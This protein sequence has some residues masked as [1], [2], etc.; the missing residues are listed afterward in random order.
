[1]ATASVVT[2]G[3]LFQLGAGTV[4]TVLPSA[5]TYT[6]VGEVR[7]FSG[8]GGG[9]ANEIDVTHFLSTAKEKRLGF[10]DQGTMSL[11]LNFVPTD[12]MQKQLEIVR[13]TGTPRNF[14]ITL[15]DGTKVELVGSV[16]TFAKNAATDDVWRGSVDI[17]VS[18]EPVWTYSA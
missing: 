18:G 5:D 17:T 3:T 15:S 1:M 8:L 2:Q 7:G 9:S 13:R 11:D 10:A 12:A 16:K 14:R 6:T 4:P